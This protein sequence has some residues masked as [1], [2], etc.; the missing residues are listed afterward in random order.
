MLQFGKVSFECSKQENS[1]NK[2]A[3][4]SA[5]CVS[6]DTSHSDV[7]DPS[8]PVPE[9][10]TTTKELKQVLHDMGN[11]ENQEESQKRQIVL[12][13]LSEIFKDWCSTGSSSS[14]EWT[15]K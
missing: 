11:Y 8:L 15:R 9:D 3:A 4:A 7:V 12:G 13:H 1:C 6:E 5:P 2:N 14:Q 10:T